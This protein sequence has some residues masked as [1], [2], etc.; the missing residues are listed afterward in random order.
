MNDQNETTSTPSEPKQCRMGCGFFGSNATG[1]CCSKCYNEMIK[2]EG[3]AAAPAPVAAVTQHQPPPASPAPIQNVTTS[4]MPAVP[5]P[6]AVAAAVA[7]PAATPSPT[8]KKK[9]K[10]GYKNLLAGMMEGS[11]ARDAEKEKESIQKVTGGGAFV[12]VDKI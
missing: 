4:P 12:K 3:V 5:E 11:G 8:K 6:T 1:D 2:K 7:Q 9:K 10:K